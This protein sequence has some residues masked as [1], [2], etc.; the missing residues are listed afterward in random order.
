MKTII[1]LNILV[2]VLFA[3]CV[4][5]YCP[6]KSRTEDVGVFLDARDGK[7][8]KWIRIGNQ[9]WMVDNLSFKSDSGCVS[10]RH[11]E[12]TVKKY[13][14]Y[15][16]WK[17]AKTSCPAGWHIPAKEELQELI[18]YLG[19]NGN[20]AYEALIL[21]RKYDFEVVNTGYYDPNNDKFN[22]IIIPF[23][24]STHFWSSSFF[25]TK[26]NQI[27]VNTL[28]ISKFRKRIAIATHS[29]DVYLPV[30]CIKDQL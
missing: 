6:K 16:S 13:G 1:V 19:E 22:R 3:G 10:F 25:Y 5:H 15:Y 18:D 9:I 11:N 29:K 4:N 17:S 8:Y 28:E 7:E 21:D 2:L 30:R 24:I 12:K 27:L 26:Q 14:Y 20:T 23:L